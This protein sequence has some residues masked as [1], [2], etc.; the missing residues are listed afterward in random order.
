M[1]ASTRIHGAALPAILLS[2]SV[3]SLLWVVGEGPGGWLYGAA[4]SLACAT[5][6]PI[7]FRLFGRHHAAGWIA[8]A[9]LGYGL[10]AFVL[11]AGVQAGIETAAGLVVLWT[12]FT[13]GVIVTCRSGRPL[14][15]L[16]PWTPAAT[17][18]LLFTLLLVPVI[19]GLPFARVGARDRAGRRSYRAYF[20]AD[21]LW[22]VAL[23]SELARLDSPPRNPYLAD[24]PLHYYWTFFN[25]PAVVTALRQSPDSIEP[26]LKANAVGAGLLFLSALFL[27]AWAAV[28]RASAVAL[29]LIAT[30]TSA[31]AEGLYGIWTLKTRGDPLTYL[32]NLNI[33]ALTA[34][35]LG[36]LTVDGLPRSLWYTPQH[37]FACAAALMALVIASASERPS[38]FRAALISGVA[39]GIAL[40][41]SPFLGGAFALI[42]GVTVVWHA[43]RHP[44]PIRA[45][46]IDATAAIPVGAAFLWCVGS[47]TFEG[48]G[49]TV[50]IGFADRARVAP[51]LTAAFALGPI[52]ILAGAGL[53]AG[54]GRGYRWQA[55]VV[56]LAAGLSLFYFVTLTTEP[57][58][59]G[60]RAGQVILVSVPALAAA[61]FAWLADR[62]YGRALSTVAFLIV[63]A[64]GL[65][66]TAIDTYNASD[67]G[68]TALGPGFR[69]TV[70]VPP[71]TESATAW[72]R[73]LT[74]EDARVQMSIGPRG[75]E[76]W[77]LIPSFAQ[78]RMAAGQPISLLASPAYALASA[79]ADAIYRTP[80]AAE[81]WRLARAL[82]IDYLFIDEVERRAFRREALDKF[83]DDEFFTPVFW[84]GETEVIK[85]K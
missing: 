13:V 33:D 52:L 70:V 27:A 71:D 23:T 29:G 10:T 1:Q 17:R 8:G 43:R 4:Y 32:R 63:L 69:W 85:V 60:W 49:G 22:H 14:V 3:V 45:L 41:C 84:K 12:A 65:P 38:Q 82:G 51:F 37:A 11:G 15:V 20:T 5:G 57:V 74:P 75:R 44:S 72:I 55:A 42:Y 46:A 80:D 77:T 67:I 53:A 6:L 73:A 81:G 18:A 59:I 21:Y 36:S 26:H 39:L 58:W 24:Q 64:I 54:R 76:T 35:F 31:S 28:P 16:P 56:S 40:V 68:N 66:T 19:T 48:A 47:G 61:F 34:W 9:V 62:K 25:V 50:A 78:R 79:Q 30:V 2:A 83:H 7:G